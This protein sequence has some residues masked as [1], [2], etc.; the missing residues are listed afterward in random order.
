MKQGYMTLLL[1]AHLPFVR[2]PEYEQF[3]EEDWLFE[4]ITETYIP[5]ICI[6]DRLLEENIDFRITMSLTPPLMSMLT[7]S[8]LQSRYLRYIERLILL[9][10]KEVQ[11]TVFMAD[12]HKT[13]RMYYDFFTKSRH[14]FENVYH[15]NL[16][17]AFR[18]FSD[19]GKLEIVT[20][21]ATHGFLPF[22][23]E[24]LEAVNAQ[25]E[26]AC[27][28]HE[29][30][31]GKRPQGIW[32]PE[33]G[34][35]D[36]LGEVLKRNGIKFFFT[37]SHGVTFAKP[38]PRYGVFAP[39]YLHSGV[40]AFAR[41]VE[42]S[43]S[44]WS[45][46]VGY[47]GDYAYREFYRDIGFDLD[48]DYIKDFIHPAGFRTNTGIKYY[49]IT[50][51]CGGEKEPYDVEKATAKTKDH[52]RDFFDR[53]L[54]HMRELSSH[55]NRPPLVVSPYDAE[56]FGHWWFEGPGFIDAL[57]RLVYKEGAREG[58][59]MVTPSEYLE[60]FPENQMV[61]LDMSSWGA[62]GYGKVWLNSSN[63]WIYRHLHKCADLMVGAA[64]R[65]KTRATWLE[66]RALNQMARELLLA[67]SSD[68]AFIMTSGTMVEY[69]NR[70]TKDHVNRFLKLHNDLMCSVVEES[71]LTTIE[72]R[73]NIFPDIDFRVYA[74]KTGLSTGMSSLT[75][76]SHS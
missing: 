2:H 28:L 58:F 41:D 70:R 45:S 26:I 37:D 71:F 59:A 10:E 24:N 4:A 76:P 35:F 40:A 65:F 66:E 56:L 43:R 42:S 44:V 60:K 34:Y 54:Q 72:F 11:R 69:A 25:I 53:R 64:S 46:E 33:C 39:V 6:F 48:F 19:A 15:R 22:M 7:D 63:D 52:A 30:H 49:R 38:Q 32:L 13:A 74:S 23:S 21:G 75:Q 1:H 55:M 14:V 18:K 73:D 61:Q 51:K 27:Q 8:L 36:G 3:L 16:V 50:D 62:A 29:K 67:Q 5:L 47:P 12:F 20:C 68:W 57:L 17:S 31:L 9:A